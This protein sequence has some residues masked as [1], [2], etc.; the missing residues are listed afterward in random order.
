M[1]KSS[2]SSVIISYVSLLSFVTESFYSVLYES[3][4]FKVIASTTYGSIAINAAVINILNILSKNPK[5]TL[6]NLSSESLN[7][8]N[9]W[10]ENSNPSCFK[11]LSIH[12]F[13]SSLSS[14]S[15]LLR[16]FFASLTC[17]STYETGIK[18]S[19]FVSSTILSSVAL[20]SFEGESV[21]TP[22]SLIETGPSIFTSLTVLCLP[23]M[24]QT[25]CS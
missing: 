13:L 20:L 16:T 2:K 12:S 1:S 18:R 25:D 14:D 15:L 23:K 5:N 7:L 9:N 8:K 4:R 17:L 21:P 10:N 19:F 11:K 3:F 24:T 6:E 22:A